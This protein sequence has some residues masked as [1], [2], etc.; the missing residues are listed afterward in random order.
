[1]QEDPVTTPSGDEPAQAHAG[2]VRPELRS[3]VVSGLRW[4]GVSQVLLQVVSFA[5]TLILARLLTP[6][7]FGLAGLALVFA[8]LAFL[9]AD[10][11]L[12]ASLVQRR[13]LTEED[14]STA[15]WSNAILGLVLTVVGIGLS[16]PLADLYHEPEVQPLFAV[17]SL[18]FLFTA[19]GTTQGALLI[20]SLSFRSLELRTM[21]ATSAS[22]AIGI[23]FATLGYGPWALIAQSLAIT[24]ISTLLLW[25]SSPWRPRFVYSTESLKHLLG[26]GS[27]VFGSKFVRY[28]ERN[29]DN[30][31]IGRYRGP[32]ALG[33]YAIAYNIMLVPV[34]KIV[35][36][37]QQVFFPAL[38]RIR[39]H[40]EA[41][42]VWLRMN[43][44]I[45]AV[46]FPGLLGMAVIAPDFV[47]V[48]LG[49][50]WRAAIP[51]LQILAWVGLIQVIAAQTTTLL[52]AVGR[53]GIVFRYSVASS[54]LSI[55]G[56]AIGVQ[57]GI[58][59]VAVGYAIANAVLIPIYLAQGNRAVGISLGEYVRAIS[60]VVQ[61]SAAMALVVLGLRLAL[62]DRL[63][64]GPR[65]V[66]L[67]AVGAAVYLPLCM[68]R[69][70]EV[71]EEIR[72]V[73]ASRR[74]NPETPSG[75]RTE[76]GG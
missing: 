51:V 63:P 68:W 5:S 31:L 43:R 39:E 58:V 44:L 60:G 71:A 23:V 36:P 56:F 45:S 1:M 30:F 18:T 41:G 29:V 38:S 59:G 9:I 46:A 14:R 19:L 55:A 32:A 13:S 4:K 17:V 42:A 64:A 7:D 34:L 53:A 6:R 74:S 16:W 8:G 37:A 3:L 40:R 20:R 27:L 11:G 48:V 33:A 76:A 57:W 35:L 10:L 66:V 26:F 65:L 72:R 2:S 54:V 69:A 12:G 50:K 73:R 15:F 75:I 52:Q 61:A 24:S 67:I 70:P 47:V 49:E 21:I 22:V 62:T 25:R 28:F